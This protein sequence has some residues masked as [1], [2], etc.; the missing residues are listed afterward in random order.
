MQH[1]P[2]NLSQKNSSDVPTNVI[3]ELKYNEHKEPSVT[4]KLTIYFK[5]FECGR[6]LLDQIDVT[7][8]QAFMASPAQDEYYK[9]MTKSLIK[10]SIEGGKLGND[11]FQQAVI[12]LRA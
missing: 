9:E 1:R 2:R 4:E 8:Q 7:Y 3:T 6:N 5:I 11:K 10:A 12:D